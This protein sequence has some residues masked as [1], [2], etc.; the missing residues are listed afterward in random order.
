MAALARLLDG[1]AKSAASALLLP[2]GV[3]ATALAVNAAVPTA[4]TLPA[5]ARYAGI[6]YDGLGYAALPAPAQRLAARSILV[7]SGLFGV[8]RGDEPVPDYRV[9]AKAA[10]P[11]V[12]IAGTAWRPVLDSVMPALLGGTRRL[13]LDLRS[14]DYRAM[15][16]PAGALAERTV[17]VRVLSPLPGGGLGVVSYPSK[18][19]KG[20]LAAVLL[21]C[22]ADGEKLTSV[23]QVAGL[24]RHHTGHAAEVDDHGSLI[25]HHPAKIVGQPA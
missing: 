12:G 22:A 10:L 23:E 11:G 20:R 8:V 18:Y 15:W 3:A 13:V 5:L 9:P 19:A 2:P 1:P 7:F 24:W 21:S 25:I 16:R 4:P 17:A 14:S 6:V